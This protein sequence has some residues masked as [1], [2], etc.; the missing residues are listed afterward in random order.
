M[1]DHRFIDRLWED[2][3]PGYDATFDVSKVKES[4][5]SPANLA[6]A[7]GYY[8]AMFDDSTH[9]PAYGEA[10]AAAASPPPQPTLYLHGAQDGCLGADI[11]GDVTGYLSNGSEQVTVPGAG[12]FLHVER[13]AI[14]NE[15][16][17]RF[18]SQDQTSSP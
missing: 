12:H 2:W 4:I 5:A 13:P 15:R 1:E 17:L 6:A 9:L 16:V 3:S 10:Q 14:V 7:I 8:R 18:L 11:V